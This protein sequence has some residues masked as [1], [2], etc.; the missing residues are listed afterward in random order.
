DWAEYL[1]AV[2]QA[3]RLIGE[4]LQA[5]EKS[6][7]SDR[8]I[9]FFMGD[10]GPGFQRGKMAVTDFGLH[11]PLAVMGPGIPS[12]RTTDA[13]LSEIDLMPTLLQLLGL[14]CPAP[15]HG[16]S[17]APL[18]RGDCATTPR[19]H[20]IG[21]IHH[22]AQSHDDG[23]QERSIY[24]G[25]YRLIYREGVEKPRDMNADLWQWKTWGNRTYDETVHHKDEFP[26]A[27]ALLQQLHPQKLG[28]R[29]PQYE[30]YDV[31]NDPFEL[32]D[33]ASRPEHA[34]TVSRL[35]ASLVEWATQTDDRYLAFRDRDLMADTWVATDALDRTLPIHEACGSPR[36]DRSVGIFYFLW[37]GSHGTQGPFD[38]A[39]IL[40]ANPSEPAWG[41]RGAFH[42]WGEPEL[43]Y[44]LADD[45]AVMRRHASMLADAGVDVAVIDV[46]NSFTYG[47]QFDVLCQTWLAMR[48]EGNA[49]PQV[50]FLAHSRQT[51]T[52]TQLYET[53][54]AKGKYRELW[55][56]WHGKPL[57]M[58]SREGLSDEIQNFFTFRES[59]AWQTEWFGDGRDK[60]PWIDNSPQ[61]FGWHEKD[62]PEQMPV[63]VAGHPVFNLGR[64]HNRG[65][66][67]KE[68]QLTTDRGVYFQQQWDR[69]L[70]VDPQFVFVTGW[71]EWVAQ[72][73]IKPDH[74]GP[75]TMIGRPIA[76]GDT[77]FVDQ[78]NREFSRDIEPMRDGHGDNYY[79]QLV[80]NIRRF[81][82][83]R[84]LPESSP[85]KTI[86]I[87][88]EFSDWSDVMPEYRDTI[89]DTTDR[90]HRG[91]G[92]AGPYIDRSGR[93]DFVALK[94][95]HDGPSVYFF[96][97]T[98]HDI[99]RPVGD[100]WMLLWIDA[101]RNPQ[102]GWR[103]Y[104]YVINRDIDPSGKSS[105]EKLTADAKTVRVGDAAFAVR[106][107]RLE[108]ALP[109]DRVAKSATVA[110]D[111][112]WTDNM[113]HPIDVADFSTGS[114]HAPNRRF[115]YRYAPTSAKP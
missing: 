9:V 26:Q 54:Y 114:D 81:K 100:H 15:M 96:A 97:E 43:G 80:D 5:L 17:V 103:G 44:Y 67:P 88:G 55:F 110:F 70:Q 7:V 41:P 87:D 27:Y 31:A 98:R 29:P 57:M 21:E 92:D 48:R 115:N 52:V 4:G 22:G 82:G 68:S 19:K 72:R 2:E 93:N 101:D 105:I 35:H 51:K 10:H 32:H 74:G 75:N 78:Y 95:T 84:P 111:F 69:A 38:V 39:K 66:Q 106:G 94:A 24:D 18:L 36:A 99:T 64:S 16:V 63:A 25:R 104:D 30:L 91:W 42:H 49:T 23:M 83:V 28:G 59:W 50:A 58:A 71:N 12:G 113:P 46:T 76:A 90:N 109:R 34:T 33:L 89:G 6:G 20:I 40:A 77:Y 85:P 45:P 65:T 60:W 56:P 37:H 8:T 107:N 108:L 1:D 53:I 86:R 3:D 62:V 13:L 73:F 47:K 11:V 79:Y 112:H 61:G 14:P 102:T